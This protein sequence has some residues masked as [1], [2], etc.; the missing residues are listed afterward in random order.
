MTGPTLP[1]ECIASIRLVPSPSPS[2][3]ALPMLLENQP[4]L[5][6][7]PSTVRDDFWFVSQDCPDYA[8]AAL[9]R[10]LSTDTLAD[11]MDDLAMGR[12]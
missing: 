12:V 2:A 4:Y 8:L 7:D 9:G 11:F 6:N 10:W 3:V 1:G 5:E